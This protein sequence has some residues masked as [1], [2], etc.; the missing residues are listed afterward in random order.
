MNT[1]RTPASLA[2]RA[3]ALFAAA[4]LFA[5]CVAAGGAEATLSPLNTPAA[6]PAAAS[7]AS[8][9]A[10][11]FYLRA[12]TSQAL[13]PQYTFGSLPPVTIANGVYLDGMVAIPMIYPGPMYVGL[14]QRPISAA[15]IGQVVAEAQKDGLLGDKTS[16]VDQPIPGAVSAHIS[17]TVGGVTHDLTGLLPGDASPTPG[18]P[19][20]PAAFVGFWNKLG[21]ID[22]W[23]AA[24]LGES[25]PYAPTG[26]AIMLTPPADASGGIAPTEIP[27]PL[28]ATF[29]KFGAPMGVV[30]YRCATVSDADLAT[31]LP[32]VQ[33]SN[34]LTV[35]VDSA[36]T[37]MSAKVEVLVPGDPGPCPA[38]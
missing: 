28:A 23:L 14:S 13:S 16:F 4:A 26:I 3:T 18:E 7:P 22:T 9:S 21:T 30:G 5:G 37:K 36:Q 24:D 1:N 6:S 27:W 38:Q 2:G 10:A 34:G 29:D 33:A 15:G 20:S 32:V 12:W 11:G 25:A 19:G 8:S 17:I 35:F 31:L